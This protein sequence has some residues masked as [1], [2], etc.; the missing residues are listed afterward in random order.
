MHRIPSTDG[1]VLAVHDLGGAGPRLLLTHATGFHGRVFA[2]LARAL[3]GRF[4]CVAPDLRG[5]GVTTTP[6]GLGYEWSGFGDDVRAV[7][8]GLGDGPWFGAGHSLGGA[9]LLMAEE[10]RPGTFAG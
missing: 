1:V 2:P 8:D 7:I 10:R 3:G 5:H 4:R 9:A 6:E